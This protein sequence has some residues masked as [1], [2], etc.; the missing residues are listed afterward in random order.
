MKGYYDMFKGRSMGQFISWMAVAV[1][2]LAF[3]LICAVYRKPA[4]KH[5]RKG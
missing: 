5:E 3:I 1:L 2:L 4:G